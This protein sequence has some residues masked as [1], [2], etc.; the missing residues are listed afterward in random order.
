MTFDCLIRQGMLLVHW[1]ANRSMIMK[2]LVL[3]S[4]TCVWKQRRVPWSIRWAKH[5][6]PALWLSL[7]P[8]FDAK[9]P[10]TETNDHSPDWAHVCVYGR[11]LAWSCQIDN[12]ASRESHGNGEECAYLCYRLE[13]RNPDL[14]VLLYSLFFKVDKYWLAEEQCLDSPGVCV[15]VNLCGIFFPTLLDSQFLDLS[16]PVFRLS[17]CW[18]VI[19]I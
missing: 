9:K 2:A 8:R 13:I 18:R 19:C 1:C 10:S 5:T 6:N 12:M 17:L 11:I 7:E 15:C 16:P 14:P 4:I 3:K